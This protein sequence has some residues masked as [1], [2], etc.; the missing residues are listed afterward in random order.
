MLTEVTEINDKTKCAANC[1]QW[2]KLFPFLKKHKDIVYLDSAATSLKPASVIE[3][4]TNYYSYDTVH[5]GRS[6][7]DLAYKVKQKIFKYRKDIANFINSNDYRN[8][9]FTS[10]ATASINE[11]A[12]YFSQIKEECEIIIGQNEHSSNLFPWIKICELNKLIK[13]HFVKLN[14]NLILSLENLKKVFTKKTRLVVMNTISNVFGKN[15]EFN[16]IGQYI[17]AK[18]CLF[19]LD[20]TQSVAHFPIDVIES[21]CDFLVISAHKMF[22]PTGSGVLYVNHNGIKKKK[23]SKFQIFKTGGGAINNVIFNK[24]KQKVKFNLKADHYS[25]E[26]GTLNYAG[27]IGIKAAVSFIQ[28]VGYNAIK[29]HDQHL[30]KKFNYFVNLPNIKPYITLYSAETDIPLFIFNVKNLF[31]QDV[32]AYLNEHSICVR[33]GEHCVLLNQ[34]FEDEENKSIRISCSIYN[35]C[36]DLQ[37]L[38]LVLDDLIQ[39]KLVD[40]GNIINEEFMMRQ[41]IMDHYANPVYKKLVT[42]KSYAQYYLKSDE[43]IDEITI[44]LNYNKLENRIIDLRF[45]GSACSVCVASCDI[46][47]ALLINKSLEQSTK[48]VNEYRAMIQN[49]VY[50]EKI[51]GN[52]ICLKNTYRVPV[53]VK[54]ATL[55]VKVLNE[56]FSRIK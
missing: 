18:K 35:T 45:T 42:D 27:I 47:L 25:L 48:I 3:K 31:C 4:I 6:Q 16:K 5:G 17:Q 21:K 13:I 53:R 49:K 40:S 44:F 43:C 23:F 37:K 1:N 38:F 36:S 30:I 29:S 39:R 20:A 14:K 51:I 46:L 12:Y 52:L 50:D 8:I 41:M 10:G 28:K 11:C 33:A 22:G 15:N 55:V 56:L 7:F 26:P 9:V 34:I 19:F 32:A 2:K 24:N 54:C